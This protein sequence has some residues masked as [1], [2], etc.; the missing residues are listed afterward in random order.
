MVAI[1][2]SLSRSLSI[3]L[4]SYQCGCA[5]K[6]DV[7]LLDL[8]IQQEQYWGVEARRNGEKQGISIALLIQS[9]DG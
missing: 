6:I 9:L 4:I 7:W 2:R 3:R 5:V 1:R 8:A